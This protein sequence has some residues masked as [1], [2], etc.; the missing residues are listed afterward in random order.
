MPLYFW[1]LLKTSRSGMAGNRPMAAHGAVK[2]VPGGVALDG[3]HTFLD[4]G[5]FHC[6]CLVEP[7]KC[8]K[9]FAVAV[10]VRNCDVLLHLVLFIQFKKR[11]IHPYGSVTF[12]VTFI[13][14]F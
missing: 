1:P 3:E 14:A 10:Q 11:K 8:Q 12:A 5:D 4:G 2:S 13:A 6:K 7:G 9:G